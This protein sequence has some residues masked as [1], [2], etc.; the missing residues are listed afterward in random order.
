MEGTRREGPVLWYVVVDIGQGDDGR[1]QQKWH[2]GFKTR[3]EA[4]GVLAELVQSLEKQTYITPQHL[5]LAKF[6]R[7]EWLPTMQTQ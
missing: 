5:S 6:A 3:R 4:E 1:R 7:D 2:G